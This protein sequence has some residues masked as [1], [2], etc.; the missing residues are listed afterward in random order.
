MKF[1]DILFAP[2]PHQ[3]RQ[4][5]IW[6][7]GESNPALRRSVKLGDAWYPGSRNPKHRL[8]TPERLTAGIGR[9]K[10]AAEKHGRDPASVGVAYVLF[11]PVET[12]AQ[13]GHDT[14]RRMM[15]G[16]AE[17]MAE[18]VRA[19]EAA[20]VQHFN[21]TFPNDDISEMSDAVQRFAEDVM[22]LVR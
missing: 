14:S 11:T 8:D 6:V 13:P 20:G 3:G 1:D 21:L 7:G 22:P 19:L 12:T 17:E 10:E 15:T 16:S 9:L 5:P 2:K 18:D 4:I